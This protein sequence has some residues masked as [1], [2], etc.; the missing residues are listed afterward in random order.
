MT[1]I[2][3]LRIFLER[4]DISCSYK[5]KHMR[6]LELIIVPA[7]QRLLED[8]MIYQF[9]ELAQNSSFKHLRNHLFTPVV[10]RILIIDL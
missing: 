7:H 9:D 10:K 5:L 2:E 4:T 8:S 1:S 3:E 6:R